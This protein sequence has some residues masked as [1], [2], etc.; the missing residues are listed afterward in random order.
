[1]KRTHPR[2]SWAQAREKL[3]SGLDVKRRDVVSSG[4]ERIPYGLQPFHC[5]I[6]HFG[7]VWEGNE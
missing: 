2:W 3:R 6:R 7:E 5:L 1:M 4:G